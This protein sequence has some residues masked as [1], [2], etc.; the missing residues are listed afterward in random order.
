MPSGKT[1]LVGGHGVDDTSGGSGGVAASV[2]SMAERRV[3]A[4]VGA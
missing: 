3:E 2:L 4:R 1:G